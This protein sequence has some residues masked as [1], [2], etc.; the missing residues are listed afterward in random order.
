MAVAGPGPM[1]CDVEP[2]TPRSAETWQDLLGTE[3]FALAELVA[4]EADEDRDTAATRVWAAG[5][6]LKKA[7]VSLDSPLVLA[8]AH[9]DGW[10]VLSS[11]SLAIASFVAPVR[12]RQERLALA[13]LTRSNRASL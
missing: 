12:D 5:E 4:R 3:R 9:A 7:G 6:C 1:G 10:V 11:G 8:S 13:V 2:V